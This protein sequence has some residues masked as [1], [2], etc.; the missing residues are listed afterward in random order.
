MEWQY[1]FNLS[2]G[3]LA[4]VF[5]WLARTLWDAVQELKADL[6]GLREEIAK[7][8]VRKDDFKEAF[9]DIKELLSKIFDRLDHKAD[10]P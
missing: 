9:R 6:A 7:D 8:L 4:A 1:L 10:K 5:G 2:L 3:V